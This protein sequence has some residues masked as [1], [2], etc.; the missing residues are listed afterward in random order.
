[1]LLVRYFFSLGKAVQLS[2]GFLLHFIGWLGA[3]DVES[4]VGI[5]IDFFDAPGPYDL[6]CLF[7]FDQGLA[8]KDIFSCPVAVEV[9]N[10][11]PRSEL[12]C[13]NLLDHGAMAGVS[14]QQF[15]RAN[16]AIVMLES[17]LL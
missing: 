11:Y 12:L 5:N 8:D 1:M 9:V 16:R 2:I 10:K 4:K 7:V 15:Y 3:L 6:N 17:I 14:V 13:F